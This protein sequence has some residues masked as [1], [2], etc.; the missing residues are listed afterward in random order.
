MGFRSVTNRL[1]ARLY[2]RVPGL[3]ER[4]GKGLVPDDDTIP[5]AQPVKPLREAVV[6]LVTTG[7]V[8]LATDPPFDMTSP[9][10]D[11]SLR[12]V[13]TDT[14]TEDLTI[15]HD[16][17]DHRDAETDLNLVMPVERLRELAQA[18]AI[19]RLH[20]PVYSLMGHIAGRQLELLRERTAPHIAARLA[21]AGVDYALLVPA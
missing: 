20:S 21:A 10:G 3:A 19:A 1:L 4:W 17:Y 18:G 13:A 6:A 2:S 11:A 16:Y 8:H 7:G 12:E 14:A 5:W 9:D 15:S